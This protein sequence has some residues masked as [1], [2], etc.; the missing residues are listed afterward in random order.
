MA[1]AKPQPVRALVGRRA[2]RS[3]RAA[4]CRCGRRSSGTRRRPRGA[5]APA[6]LPA[7]PAS[8]LIWASSLIAASSRSARWKALSAADAGTEPKAKGRK[9]DER[10]KKADAGGREHGW[11]PPPP[12]AG[13]FPRGDHQS[14]IPNR[15]EVVTAKR[16]SFVAAVHRA[17]I[18]WRRSAS[19]GCAPSPR[20]TRGW[21]GTGGVGGMT[22]CARLPPLHGESKTS[23]ARRVGADRNAVFAADP[24]PDPPPQAGEGAHRPRCRR[25]DCPAVG[26][27]ARLNPGPLS[28]LRPSS[29]PCGLVRCIR[30]GPA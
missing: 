1:R 4:P 23:R 6:A 19:Q 7:V 28:R 2:R 30:S 14:T 17:P 12:A 11:Y 9:G 27:R 10:G 3:G 25:R 22:D 8:V 20:E 29:C 18:N 15:V 13:K 26:W 21:C 16:R 24:H 5:A